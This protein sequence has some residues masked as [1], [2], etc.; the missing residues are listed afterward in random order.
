[1]DEPLKDY[2]MTR[3]I[4]GVSSSSFI[5]NM[6]VKQNTLDLELKYSLASKMVNE[7]FCV[8]DGLTGADSVE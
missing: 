7:S 1:M 8:D 6:C 3:F 5:A 2:R 4:F